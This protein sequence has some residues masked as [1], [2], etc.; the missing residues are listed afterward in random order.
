[1]RG[2]AVWGTLAPGGEERTRGR[3]GLDRLQ[4]TA[5][6]VGGGVVKKQVL[7][8]AQDDNL[9]ELERFIELDLASQFPNHKIPQLPNSSASLWRKEFRRTYCA[10]TSTLAA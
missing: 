4:R 7:R 10:P 2:E 6:D 3:I 1:M 5:L 9:I 8:F